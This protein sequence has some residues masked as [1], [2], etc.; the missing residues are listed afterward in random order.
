MKKSIIIIMGLNIWLLSVSNVYANRWYGQIIDYSHEER[1][2]LFTMI[3]SGAP[4]VY[5][6]VSGY[7]IRGVGH[8]T[9]TLY[10]A[11]KSYCQKWC[12]S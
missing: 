11:V 4:N 1:I 12:L 9:G 10:I 6:S 7:F 5:C 8:K 3:V 2:A